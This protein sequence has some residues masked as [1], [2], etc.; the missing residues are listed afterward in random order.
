MK[1]SLGACI[2]RACLKGWGSLFLA[3]SCLVAG[4]LL[5]LNAADLVRPVIKP[6]KRSA[7][8]EALPGQSRQVLVNTKLLDQE[9]F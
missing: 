9:A 3:S 8:K 2:G 5:S 6:S 1:H 7:P 4:S